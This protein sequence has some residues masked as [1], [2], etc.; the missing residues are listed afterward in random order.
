ML[1][2]LTVEGL[3]QEGMRDLASHFLAMMVE[4]VSAATAVSHLT[5]TS[6][7]EPFGLK[8]LVGE[9]MYCQEKNCEP[10]KGTAVWAGAAVHVVDVAWSVC[11]VSWFLV[12]G[13]SSPISAC[14]LRISAHS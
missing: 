12:A 4:A 11:G 14:I 7:M 2:K 1:H 3:R 8:A 13:V 5:S 10:L 9:T 6:L